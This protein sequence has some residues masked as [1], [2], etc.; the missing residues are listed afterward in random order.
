MMRRERRSDKGMNLTEE[1]KA[2]ER[3]T[4]RPAPGTRRTEAREGREVIEK[5]ASKEVKRS[6]MTR[7]RIRIG[8]EEEIRA[9][10]RARARSGG[11]E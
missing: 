5:I 7:A 9:K 10:V 6:G 1:C 8:E 4:T 3:L 2:K 11:G